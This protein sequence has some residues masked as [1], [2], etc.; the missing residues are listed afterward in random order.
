M[1]NLEI[2]IKDFKKVIENFKK[3]HTE[4]EKIINS[5]IEKYDLEKKEI[6]EVCQI[7]KFVY[8]IDTEIKIIE[9]PQPPSPDFIISHK[10]K[11][12]GL[13]HT[14]IITEDASRYF[15]IKTLLEYSEQ[16]FESKY[17]N[18]NVHATI[19][20]LN[21]QLDYK[22]NE[23]AELAEKIADFVQLTRMKSEFDCPDYIT[24]IRTTK[25]S[26]VSFSYKEKNDQAKYLTRERLQKEILK[27]ESKIPNYKKSEFELTEYWLTLLIGSLS[28]VSYELNEMEN[29]EMESKFDRVYLMTDFDAKI[30]R[31]K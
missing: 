14:Q 25:H 27:K 29:Y 12:I 22:Q 1:M 15:K 19:S 2:N 28:S 18:I 30:I 23:K 20:I 16:I 5:I 8:K 7:G 3:E 9:K 10:D 31:I 24:G 13:E 26:Q 4:L 11:K 21:D 17:P 6:L